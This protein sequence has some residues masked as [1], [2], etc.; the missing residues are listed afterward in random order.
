MVSFKGI[1]LDIFKNSFCGFLKVPV[2]YFLEQLRMSD[3]ELDP[4]IAALLAETQDSSR[5]TMSDAPISSFEPSPS[6]KKPF[7]WDEN[8]AD[9]VHKNVE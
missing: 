7:W 4:T 6:V 5:P 1:F 3:Q 2:M 8:S 9:A